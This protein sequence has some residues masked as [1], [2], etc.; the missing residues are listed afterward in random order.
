MVP[1]PESHIELNE[2]VAFMSLDMDFFF[3]IV[4]FF[5]ME[6]TLVVFRRI[7]VKPVLSSAA[8]LKDKQ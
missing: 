5:L 6:T 3:F 4:I 8:Y 7:A 1:K 2:I